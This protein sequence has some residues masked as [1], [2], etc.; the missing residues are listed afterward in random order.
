MYILL[1]EISASKFGTGLLLLLS[2]LLLYPVYMPG[3]NTGTKIIMNA[4]KAQLQGA[5]L[6]VFYFG[7]QD[8]KCFVNIFS[9]LLYLKDVSV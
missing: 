6:N 1:F 9:I 7:L 3:A 5:I 8:E 2:V 4:T